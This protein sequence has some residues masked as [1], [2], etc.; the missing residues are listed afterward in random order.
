[1]PKSAIAV[2]YGSWPF[3][4]MRN[5]KLFSRV[6]L[7]SH[8]A[9]P[10]KLCKWANCF[11]PLQH[12][13][14][15]LA[16]WMGVRR[17]A[18]VVLFYIWLM[19]MVNISTCLLV[20]CISSSVKCLCI[21]FVHFI[22]GVLFHGCVLSSLYILGTSPFFDTLFANVFSQSVVYSFHLLNRV[23]GRANVLNFDEIQFIIFSIYGSALGNKFQELFSYS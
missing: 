2:L 23:F 1:M 18:I 22:F 4:S 8:F 11:T 5:A 10:Q 21:T 20:V 9:L 3:S 17:Y 7:R 13:L 19:A 14:N 15:I 12:F 6:A 16:V